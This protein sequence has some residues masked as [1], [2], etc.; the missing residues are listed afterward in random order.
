MQ[1]STNQGCLP[2]FLRV[3]N[4]TAAAGFGLTALVLFV[5]SMSG[6][7][8]AQSYYY[9]ALAAFLVFLLLLQL[10][11][12]VMAISS[13]PTPIEKQRKERSLLIPASI[14]LVVFG[15]LI[16]LIEFLV[17]NNSSLILIPILLILAT[18]LPIWWF[19]EL[20]RRKL[21]H[22][23][24]LQ[25]WGAVSV[26]TTITPIAAMIIE[27]ILIIALVI[28]GL[29][30][31]GNQPGLLNEI[32]QFAQQLQA[33]PNLQQAQSLAENVLKNPV[34]V[35]LVLV[36]MSLLVPLVEELAKPLGLYIFRGK[37]ITPG[38]GFVTGMIGGAC[39]G[40]MESMLLLTSSVQAGVYEILLV[41]VATGLLHT[42]TAGLTGWGFISAR[43]DKKPG[44]WLLTLLAGI[45]LHGLW[46]FFGVMVGIS[47][48]VTQ[49]VTVSFPAASTLAK[50]SPYVLGFLA[51]G[52]L[53]ILILMNRHLQKSRAAEE[54]FLSQ[55][56][57]IP[58]SFPTYPSAGNTPV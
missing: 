56:P 28:L 52:M 10:F 58:V 40:F 11:S 46:N 42:T 6:A 34:V 29:I 33:N 12:L 19:V 43:Y 9:F 27:I 5:S 24:A 4:I 51:I 45:G 39:F 47:P 8:A 20:G 36:F 55:P 7:A 49:N 3:L 31:L 57:P 48:L 18:G 21:L 16:V 14:G 26:G 53:T 32:S 17:R 44:R 54:S 35:T 41:R 23:T 1:S 15:G 38:Q 13:R 50:L 25:T 22:G 30:L 37:R 2:V